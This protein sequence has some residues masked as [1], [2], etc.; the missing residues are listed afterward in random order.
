MTQRYLYSVHYRR[1]PLSPRT[2]RMTVTAADPDEARKAVSRIDHRFT[3]TVRTPQRR[4]I[5][6]APAN[7]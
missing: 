4:G 7:F 5:A 3:S 6:P 2:Y 1:D